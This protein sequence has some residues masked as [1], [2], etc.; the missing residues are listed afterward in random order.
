MV[1]T[2]KVVLSLSVVTVDLV[3]RVINMSFASPIL[4]RN[5]DENPGLCGLATLEVESKMSCVRTGR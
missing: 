4:T 3:G 1:W 5:F 2:Q